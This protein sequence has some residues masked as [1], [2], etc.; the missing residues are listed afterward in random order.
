MQT[1]DLEAREV[2]E[3]ATR[4]WWLFLVTGLV[5]LLVSIIV[6]RFDYTTV[7]AVSILFGVIALFAGVN[8][9]FAIGASHGW[10]RF[11]HGLLGVAFVVIGFV[12]FI[13]PG[14]TFR[15]LAAVISFFFIFKGFFDIIVSIATKEES[16]VWWLL[17]TAGIV[18]VL[19]G[20]WAA[21]Y[22][23]RS[24]VLLVAWVGISALFRGI[25]EVIFAFKLRSA[26]QSVGGGRDVAVA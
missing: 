14:D 7:A 12:A 13:H 24:A 8:E 26:G 15:A 4:W 9:L 1:F 20:F 5:W 17:L 25:T 23:G 11:L 6:L 19:I 22:Y 21:G 3:R 16:S 18:E 2:G 10:W